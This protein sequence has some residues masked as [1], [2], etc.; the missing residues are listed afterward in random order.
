MQKRK[1][2]RTGLDVSILG[3][4]GH[5]YPV[6]NGAKDFCAPEQRAQLIHHLVTAGVNYFDTTWL[7]EVELLADSLRRT[8]IRATAEAPL[9]VSLQYV[10]GISDARWRDKLRSEVESR[11]AVMGYSRAPLFIMGVGNNKP[12]VGEIMA[13]CEALHGLKAEGLIENIGISCHELTAFDRLA[14]VIEQADLIDYMMIRYNWKY[15]QAG[16]RLFGVAKA[17]NIGIALM[18]SFCWDC[19]PDNWGRRISIFEP[20]E[21]A[22]RTPH[23]DS[24]N[25]AQRALLWCI[26]TTPCATTVPSIN[27]LWEADQLIQ[28]VTTLDIKT[29]PANSDTA[30]FD[31]YLNRLYDHNE[32]AQLAARA[33]SDAV[34][35]RAAALI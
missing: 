18:K 28:S 32:L 1:L 35:E 19:G 25:A 5:T 8:D 26:Q 34:R 2:G 14:T 20:T 29:A 17:Y 22:G 13:A 16:E 3:V 31:A 33:E 4:G 7:N 21:S 6:G 27:A 10:D 24:L 15:Q 12:P 30:D 11:L 9:H 23:P